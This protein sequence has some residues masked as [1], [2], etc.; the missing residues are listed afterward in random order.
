MPSS[1]DRGDPEQHRDRFQLGQ[2]PGV[3]RR[4]L[5]L[6]V[7][8]NLHQSRVDFLDWTLFIDNHVARETTVDV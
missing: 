5:G 4:Y 8:N 3:W 1:K 6:E 2:T 7:E